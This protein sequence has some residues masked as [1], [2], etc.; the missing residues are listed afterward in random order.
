[1]ITIWNNGGEIVEN[2]KNKIFSPFFTTKKKG[3]GIGLCVSRKIINEHKGEINL[4]TV[5][6]WTGFEITLK[7]MKI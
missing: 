7:G 4:K 2:Q 6:G 1:M 5:N 3:N